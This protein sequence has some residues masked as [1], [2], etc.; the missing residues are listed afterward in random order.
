MKDPWFEIDTL[1]RIESIFLLV[2]A[3]LF[4]ACVVIITLFGSMEEDEECD[5]D[6]TL[7][8]DSSAQ[9]GD[10]ENCSVGEDNSNMCKDVVIET[11]L[12]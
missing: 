5:Y 6:H 9:G 10:K 2:Y 3:N 11:E 1:N 7:I 8:D 4:T 12:M